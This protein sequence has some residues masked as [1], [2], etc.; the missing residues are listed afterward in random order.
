MKNSWVQA[1]RVMQQ[2]LVILIRRAY[3]CRAPAV[4]EGEGRRD[5]RFEEV[6]ELERMDGSRKEKVRISRRS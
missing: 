6:K 2:S 3:V 4:F 5:L 1:H